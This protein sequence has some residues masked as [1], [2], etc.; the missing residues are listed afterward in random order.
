MSKTLASPTGQPGLIAE[1]GAQ[2]R[3]QH[4]GVVQLLAVAGPSPAGVRAADRIR[5]L[6]R[7]LATWTR[8]DAQAQKQSAPS[9]GPGESLARANI[10]FADFPKR[11]LT[12]PQTCRC[13]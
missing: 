10:K 3:R 4:W 7:S 12:E 13:R 11:T 8:G 2:V 1:E 6:V 9:G 5:W